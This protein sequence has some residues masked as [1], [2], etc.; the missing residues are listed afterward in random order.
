MKGKKNEM[1]RMFKRGMAL[2]MALAM[3]LTALPATAF[4]ETTESA[5]QQLRAFDQTVL[6]A[7]AKAN[8]E[9]VPAQGNDG[10]ATW[11]FDDTAH[12]WH[13][14]WGGTAQEGEVDSGVVSESNPIWIQTGFGQKWNVD[15]ITY[16][17][18]QDQA[19]GRINAYTVYVANLEDP[20]AAPTET[21]FVEVKSG[22]LGNVGTMSYIMLDEVVEATHVRIAVTSVN[23]NGGSNHVAAQNIKIYGYD[24]VPEIT[25]DPTDSSK[26]YP[27]E[28]MTNTAGS[29]QPLH[30]EKEGPVILAFDSN[31]ETYW[32]SNWTAQA[33][34]NGNFWV[35]MMFEETTEVTGLRYLP[36][37]MGNGDIIGYIIEGTEDGETW[38]MLT[39]GRWTRSGWQVA[40]FE[41]QVLAGVRLRG[42]S[43]TSDSSTNYNKFA[44]AKEIRVITV[45]PEVTPVPV[46]KEELQAKVTKYAEVDTNVYTEATAT[47]FVNALTAAQEVL[48]NETA[49]QETVN[50]ALADLNAAYE[51]LV[52]LYQKVSAEYLTATASSVDGHEA[53]TYNKN[54]ESAVDGNESTFWASSPNEEMSEG[55]LKVDLGCLN[56]INQVD[57]T[58]R[59]Y[60]SAGWDCVGNLNNYTISVSTDGESW[61]D[62]ASGNTVD[63]TTEIKFNPVAARYVKI[64]ATESYHYNDDLLNTCLTVAELAVYAKD[65]HTVEHT[66]A[67]DAA[68]APTC[69]ETGLT[70]GKKCSVCGET[71]V[72]QTV[73]DALGHDYDDG[74]VT[75][76]A[77]CTEDGVKTFTCSACGDTHTETIAAT[78]HTEEIL[79]AVAPTCTATGLT[80]GKKCSV[81]G[82][83]LVK[84]EVV[85]ALGHKEVEVG[86]KAP[87]CT[88]NGFSSATQCSVCGEILDASEEIPALGHDYDDGVVTKAATCTEDGVKTFKCSVCGDSYTEAIAATGHTE[89]A[90]EAVAPTCT[91]TGLTEGTKCSVCG[92]TLVA[93]TEVAALGHS[94]KDGTCTNCGVTVKLTLSLDADPGAGGETGYTVPEGKDLITLEYNDTVTVTA[95]AAE[96]YEFAYWYDSDT[97]QVLSTETTYEFMM[98]KNT[99]LKAAFAEKEKITVVF[100]TSPS[101]NNAEVLRETVGADTEVTAPEAFAF[102]NYEFLGWDSNGDGIADLEDKGVAVPTENVTYVA[103]YKAINTYTVTIH[104]GKEET[105]AEYQKGILHTATAAA[106]AEGKVFAGWYDNGTLV[107]MDKAYTFIVNRN[108]NLKAVYD[109]DEPEVEGAVFAITESYRILNDDGKQRV[110][111]QISWDALSGCKILGEGIVR[112]YVPELGTEEELVLG[113]TKSGITTNAASIVSQKGTF[114]ANINIGAAS[115]NRDKTMYARGYV[116]YQDASGEIHTI[117]TNVVELKPALAE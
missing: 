48:V 73:V 5:T 1:K 87:T 13:S 7:N 63:G 2:I 18:R 37:G 28:K 110:R 62:V 47:V 104:N 108:M 115:A 102:P 65:P 51:A 25:L 34:S 53:E 109:N 72:A 44:N 99:S 69:T 6:A 43:T 94:Y 71:L 54:P 14:R 78:S 66:V 8:S 42:V 55:W 49:D 83:I 77:T 74:V 92:E 79:A 90:I 36:R 64:T 95:A 57:Y 59:Y 39:S 60:E 27:V 107:S 105:T 30:A 35:A 111:I 31:E 40:Q 24:V 3:I 103:I 10:G 23:A 21:D 38:T 116:R 11:A 17:P 68:V 76:A 117:Y 91:A 100:K 82:E 96:G 9:H 45:Q 113:S 22:T 16:L 112:T 4:A 58:M 106:P 84:Q 93:Q 29:E 12:W 75:K 114:A 70:E 101:F 56:T 50:A 81:C 80:E 85:A 52:S 88:D 32:H 46:N 33:A 86:G 19:Y 20:T 98:I 26:D 41:P 15:F 89:E 67:V 61:E 97:E